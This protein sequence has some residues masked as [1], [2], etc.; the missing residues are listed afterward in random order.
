MAHMTKLE[1]YK[2]IRNAIKELEF[3]DYEHL[4]ILEYL[5]ITE[6]EYQF[7]KELRI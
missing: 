6:E 7:F 5:G 2:I 4:A 1:L 3:S